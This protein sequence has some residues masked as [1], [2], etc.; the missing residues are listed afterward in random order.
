MP[1]NALGSALLLLLVLTLAGL[2]AC[3]E[4]DHDAVDSVQR[5]TVGDTIFVRSTGG[6]LGHIEPKP[7]LVVGA[8]DGPEEFTF[9]DIT[10]LIPDGSGGLYAFD[11]QVPAIRHYDSTGH[12]IGQLGSEGQGPGEYSDAVLGLALSSDGQLLAYDGGNNRINVYGS[13]GSPAAHWQVSSGLFAD[14][15]LLV[16]SLDHV[17]VKIVT[18]RWDR[19]DVDPEEAFEWPWPIGL[20]HLDTLGSVVDTILPPTLPDEPGG[21]TGPLSP[22]KVFSVHPSM[23]VVGIN[24]VYEFDIRRRDGKTYRVSLD[25]E[26]VSVSDSEWRILEARRQWEIRTENLSENESPPRTARVKPAYRGFWIAEDGRIWVHRFLQATESAVVP[27]SKP[28]EPPPYPAEV[29]GYD[30]FEPDGEY[31][32]HVLVPDETKIHWIG[33]DQALGVRRGELDEQYIVRMSLSW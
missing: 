20:L 8:V 27:E 30:V 2:A 15:A 12:Y 16:D 13:D 3:R 31:L 4:D 32:V 18:T 26:P 25:Y 5:D 19:K 22:V 14:R 28:G 9:G 29:H 6:G 23:T 10:A 17:Y 33:R 7:D 21:P 1:G 11:R 24:N